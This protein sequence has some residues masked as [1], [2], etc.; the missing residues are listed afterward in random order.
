MRAK[1]PSVLRFLETR[2]G[3]EVSNLSAWR[4]ATVG[5]MTSAFNFTKPDS[6]IPS[7]PSTLAAIPSILTE[8]AN[9]LGGFSGFTLPTPQVTPTV[10]LV[11]TE[12]KSGVFARPPDATHPTPEAVRHFRAKDRPSELP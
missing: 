11:R 5:D 8:C 6:S 2:F 3:T 4:R 10:D 1:Y 12:Q 9:N 7:L